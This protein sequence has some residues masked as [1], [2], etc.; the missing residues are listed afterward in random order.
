MEYSLPQSDILL[1]LI[2]TMFF[3]GKYGIKERLKKLKYN[4]L[5]R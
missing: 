3:Y 4:G 1:H 5:I 2:A